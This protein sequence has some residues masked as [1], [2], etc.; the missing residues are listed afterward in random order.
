MSF[1]AGDDDDDDDDD[2]L[3]VVA[4]ASVDD[5]SL[6]SLA[7]CSLALAL[8]LATLFDLKSKLPDFFCFI[9]E[10]ISVRLL[11][12]FRKLGMFEFEFEFEWSVSTVGCVGMLASGSLWLCVRLSS[13]DDDELFARIAASAEE[14]SAVV[15]SS[16]VLVVMV[17]KESS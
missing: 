1:L 17:V 2:D 5:M 11:I 10:S 9:F 3:A 8:K 15:F 13:F 16:L 12:R 14:S 7:L 6:K 4:L